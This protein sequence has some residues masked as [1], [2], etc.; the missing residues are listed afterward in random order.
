MKKFRS[1]VCA[2]ITDDARARVLVFSRVDHTND[3]HRWQFPQ[4]GLHPGEDPMHGLLRELEEEIGTAEVIVLEQAPQ[5]VRYEFPPEVLALLA[6]RDPEKR[7]YDGQEQHWF[8]VRL[9]EGTEAIHFEHDPPEF[10]AFR[11][12]TP[13]EAV[14]LVVP[15]KKEA[16]LQ[17]LQALGLM[18]RK[19]A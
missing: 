16:Y 2:V 18:P 6:G 10:D 8:L 14:S 5:P 7:G 13:G 4:G 11:W 19:R 12:V 15:F 3:P 17:G 1:N 9:K